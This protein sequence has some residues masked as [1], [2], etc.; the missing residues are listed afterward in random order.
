MPMS[1]SKPSFILSLTLISLVAAETEPSA[2]PNSFAEGVLVQH[3]VYGVGR[4]TAVSGHGV[5]R[6]VK[7]RFAQG[8]ERTFIAEKA[9]LSIVQNG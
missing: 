4:V 3:H 8:G 2:S 9:K 6:K 7:I 5:M 1:L